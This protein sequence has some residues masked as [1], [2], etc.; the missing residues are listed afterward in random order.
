MQRNTP[1]SGKAE[2]LMQE[3]KVCFFSCLLKLIIPASV[4]WRR[5]V[6]DSIPAFHSSVLP[7]TGRTCCL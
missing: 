6:R 4:P 2:Y 1:A 3:R 5:L 7:G